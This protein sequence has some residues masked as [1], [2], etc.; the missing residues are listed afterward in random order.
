MGK[1]ADNI[2]IATGSYDKAKEKYTLELTGEELCII[3]DWMMYIEDEHNDGLSSKDDV[4]RTLS[5]RLA[6]MVEWYNNP[7]LTDMDR[8][9]RQY[10]LANRRNAELEYKLEQINKLVKELKENK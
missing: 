10:A 3:Y 6:K 8:L 2:F 4:I 9:K 7:K 1:F 5:K